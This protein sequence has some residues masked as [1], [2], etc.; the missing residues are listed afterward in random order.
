V[1]PELGWT[2][3]HLKQSRAR[4]HALPPAGGTQSIA[5]RRLATTE[6]AEKVVAVVVCTEGVGM[7]DEEE[8]DDAG[9]RLRGLAP[10]RGSRFVPHMTFPLPACLTTGRLLRRICVSDTATVQQA[11]VAPTDCSDD[12][13]LL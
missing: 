5:S 3:R 1:P 13:Q 4:H 7:V 10:A 2:W 6:T 11:R 8:R 12:S 9:L